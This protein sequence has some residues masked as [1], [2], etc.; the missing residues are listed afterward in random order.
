MYIVDGLLQGLVTAVS[1]E[2]L[3]Y[4]ILGAIL[5]LIIGVIPGLSGHFAMAMMIPFVFRMDATVAVTFILAAHAAVAQGG[6]VTAILFA[7]PGTGQNAATLLDGPAMT[8]KGEAGRAVGAAMTACFLGAFFGVFV[9]TALLPILRR[10]VLMFGPPE[11]FMLAVLALTFIA[12]LGRGGNI[13]K[14]LIAGGL[15]LLFS[16]VGVGNVTGEG[17]FTFGLLQLWDGLSMV[18]VL[19]GIFAVSEM[20]NLWIIGGSLARKAT[21]QDF[22]SLQK[23]IFGGILDT[24]RRWWLVVR[25]SA[26]GTSMGLIPGLGS[27]PAAFVAYAHAKQTSKNPEKFGTGIVEGVIAPES[28]N[29]AVEGGALAST[30][31]FGIP[32][33]SSMAILITA[34]II[35]GVEPGPKFMMQHLDLV[36][37]MIWTV[38][39]GNLV[40]TLLG[41]GVA[42]PLARVTFLRGSLLVPVLLTIILTGSFVIHSTWFDMIVALIFGLLGYAMKKLDYSRPAFIIGF[43]LG[44]M[45]ERNLYLSIKLYGNTFFL[46]PLAFGLMVLT[47]GVLAY[48]VRKILRTKE[49]NILVADEASDKVDVQPDLFFCFLLILLLA[50]F[51]VAALG[52]KPVTRRAPVIVMIPLAVMLVGQAAVLVKKLKQILA[53]NVESSL[54]PRIEEKKLRKAVVLLLWMMF[55]MLVIY[56]AGHVAGILIFLILILRFASHERWLLSISLGL[57]VTISLYVLFEIILMIPLYPGLIYKYASALIWA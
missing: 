33:S 28:S 47:I 53:E 49:R 35:L 19:L 54:L 15:G 3:P 5:G 25:C 12:V 30:L 10:V 39:L 24:L 51:F 41:M 36:F 34:L 2:V 50:V 9:L 16:F 20:L 11:F 46:E 38:V 40:G 6:G 48:N 21:D 31:A 29:D 57:A 37:L 56:V 55:L 22:R 26:I 43:V 7:T 13:N 4:L 27:A 17:R 44:L 14:G 18:P 52:Y 1:W 32:G 45:V 42:N 23:Q 8:E